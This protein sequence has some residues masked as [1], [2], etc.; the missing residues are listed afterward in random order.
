M[1][2][3]YGVGSGASTVGADVV[4]NKTRVMSTNMK[5]MCDLLSCN[6]NMFSV[7]KKHCTPSLSFNHVTVL[8]YLSKSSS[9]KIDLN[10]HCDVEI[11]SNNEYKIAN[12]Q[13]E[14][15]PTVVLSFA[16]TKSVEMYKRQVLNNKFENAMHVGELKME[17]GEMFVLHPYDERVV[18]RIVKTGGRKKKFEKEEI[19]SQFRHALSFKS[20][21]VPGDASST[22]ECTY[23]VSISVCFHDV[24]SSQWFH[25]HHSIVIRKTS[26]EKKTDSMTDQQKKKQK[27]IDNKRDQLHDKEFQEKMTSELRCFHKSITK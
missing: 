22:Q 3:C 20:L 25:P 27:L 17:D 26:D 8:Y 6:S 23:A 10:P 4:T 16:A 15:S 13:T 1:R 11:S 21:H 19:R 2:T 5:N 14:N 7:N 9:H 12:S 24:K 18:E